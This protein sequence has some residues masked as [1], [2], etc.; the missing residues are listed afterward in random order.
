M[1]LDRACPTC[2]VTAGSERAFCTECGT[3]L[4]VPAPPE[5]VGMSCASCGT[6]A[7]EGLAF[8]TA[9]G[10]RLPESPAPTAQPA[11]DA[12]C[13]DCSAPVTHGLVFCT[14]CGHRLA[15]PPVSPA[16]M[17]VSAPA[18]PDA[19]NA[20]ARPKV[21][22]SGGIVPLIAVVALLLVAAV[23]GGVVLLR[24]NSNN[25]RDDESTAADRATTPSTTGTEE[26]P[27]VAEP[28]ATSPSASRTL[29]YTCW[30]GS[31]V[32][33]LGRCT[34]PAGLAGL[35]WV[36]PPAAD[37]DCR[38]QPQA[39]RALHWVCK[40]VASSGDLVDVK[41]S[42]WYRWEDAWQHYADLDVQGGVQTWRGLQ[43]WNIIARGS[44][45][46][47]KVAVL[48]PRAPWSVTV[49]GWSVADRDEILT[50]LEFREPSKLRGELAD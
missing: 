19:V 34:E 10:T 21:R 17:P 29:E 31:R 26:A 39:D 28:T 9:C 3:R 7:G 48:Y 38:R 27:P 14:N 23:M 46:Q 11:P 33:A 13:P 25:A 44:N 47:Y 50:A 41:Y 40:I 42:E 24:G 22:R 36:F 35:Q 16:P 1:T 12:S 45:P 5:P 20:V 43:R 2:G 32:I 15:S 37:Q 30:N 6:A 49:Y 18:G 4:P 8:C